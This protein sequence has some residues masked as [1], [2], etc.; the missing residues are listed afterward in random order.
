LRLRWIDPR[1]R[2][3]FFSPCRR[4]LEHPRNAW[5]SDGAD[6]EKFPRTNDGH[7]VTPD[8]ALAADG[9]V[10]LFGAGG[11]LV[12]ANEARRA[13]PHGPVTRRVVA[14]LNLVAVLFVVRVAAWFTGNS[15]LGT[16]E[17]IL[18]SAAPLCSLIVAEGLLR[19]HAPRWLKIALVV[20]PIALMLMEIIPTVPRLFGNDLLLATVVGGYCAVAAL[21]WL[22]DVNSLTAAENRTVRRLLLAVVVLAPL[23]LTDFR[24]LWP[25]IYVRMGAVGAL[26]VLYLGLGSGNLHVP[27]RARLLSLG[28]F[29]LIAALL[30]FEYTAIG[31]HGS[32]DLFSS[33][34]VGFS[35]LLFAAL[36]SEARGASLERNRP[37][38]PMIGAKTIKAFTERLA[39]HPLLSGSR[40]L[41]GAMLDDVRDPSFVNLLADERVLRRSARPWGRSATDD[42]VERAISLMTAYDATHLALLTARPLRVIAV[43]LPGIAVDERTESEIELVRLVGALAYARETSL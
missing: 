3:H 19:R 35:G 41:S 42:G 37:A 24:S 18:A 14:A 40:V 11:V 29:L 1:D 2:G 25:D 9:L 22:R 32:G 20:S 26:L 38:Q 21:L 27:L 34:T 30:G 7:Q 15:L 6:R 23:I 4:A 43:Q 17:H 8:P 13:D 12:V 16:L 36:F 28:M 5:C 31:Q 10:N 39:A 33:T